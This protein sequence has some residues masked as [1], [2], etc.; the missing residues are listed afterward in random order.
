MPK[1]NCKLINP[2]RTSLETVFKFF[3]SLEKYEMVLKYTELIL[4]T[5]NINTLQKIYDHLNENHNDF[6][7]IIYASK[8]SENINDDCD[9]WQYETV[10]EVMTPKLFKLICKSFIENQDDFCHTDEFF[11]KA[12]CEDVIEYINIYCD[13]FHPDH[14]I[15]G[16]TFEQCVLYSVL[17]PSEE[18]MV[19]KHLIEKGFDVANIKE[20]VFSEEAIEDKRYSQELLDYLTT[21]NG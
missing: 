1:L 4:K 16:E 14:L 12:S 8:L 10:G 15:G 11:G 6:C 7:A 5:K 9:P 19:V 13:V 2:A 21:F 17:K 20:E 18:I 3:D